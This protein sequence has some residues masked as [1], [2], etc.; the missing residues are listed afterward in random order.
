MP[1]SALLTAAILT[2]YIALSRWLTAADFPALRCL[3]PGLS[4]ELK[5]CG[6]MD[7]M[8]QATD[9]VVMT[10]FM[11]GG[12]FFFG[13]FAIIFGL[14]V[15]LQSKYGKADESIERKFREYQRRKLGSDLHDAASDSTRRDT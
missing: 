8:M 14:L 12:M 2:L 7:F 10:S 9:I 1:L 3:G 11:T 4:E 5:S 6:F 15:F 13:P